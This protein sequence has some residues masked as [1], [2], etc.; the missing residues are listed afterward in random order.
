MRSI[1]LC[2]FLCLIISVNVKANSVI[3]GETKTIQGVSLEAIDPAC[4]TQPLDKELFY[5]LASSNI[6]INLNNRS[7]IKKLMRKQLNRKSDGYSKIQISLNNIDCTLDGEYRLT[8]DLTDHFSGALSSG[9]FIVSSQAGKNFHSIKVKL[10]NGSIDNIEKFKLLVPASRSGEA[11]VIVTHLFSTIGFLAPRTA[12]VN[13]LHDGVRRRLLFQEDIEKG[14]FEHNNVHENFL[15][16]GDEQYG[17]G[18]AFSMPVIVNDRLLTS[19]TKLDLA[20]Y[21]YHDLSMVYL[22]SGLLDPRINN[23]LDRNS[24]F[25]DSIPTPDFFP[26][27]SRDEITLFSMLS[28]ATN[29]YEGLS[30]D[31][32]RFIYDH[33]SRRFRP[34]YYDGHAAIYQPMHR[35][36]TPFSFDKRHREELIKKF[37]N[38]NRQDF[39][40]NL[41]RLGVEAPESKIENFLDSVLLNIEK[42]TAAKPQ[43]INFEDEINNIMSYWKNLEDY[44]GTKVL[45]DI[46]FVIKDDL[47]AFKTCNQNSSFFECNKIEFEIEKL[48]LNKSLLTQDLTSIQK[49]LTETV[50]LGNISSDKYFDR[51][52]LQSAIFNEI[53]ETTFLYSKGI[54]VSL[55]AE[56]KIIVIENTPLANKDQQVSISGGILKGWKIQTAEGTRLGY[57]FNENDRLSNTHLTGCITLSDIELIETT[58]SIGPSNCE[59]ALHFVRALGRNIKV[60]IQEARSDALDADFSNILFTS[61]DIF[62]AGNDCIDMS[63][64]TYLI[65]KAVLKQCGDKGI[66]GGEKS[67]IKITNVSIDGSLLGIVSK[68]SSI[69]DVKK[70]SISNT[71]VCLAAYRK[72]KE[73]LGGTINFDQHKCVIKNLEIN[74]YQQPGSYI[75]KL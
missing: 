73:F 42:L 70:F 24:Y 6:T 17:L 7:F 60:L 56:E 4:F 61:L 12:M 5:D 16:E 63:S 66:S 74:S 34:I 20:S 75:T 51:P 46:S 39:I 62:R 44:K 53:P 35:S 26:L 15:F 11:E 47:N 54:S 21:I 23:E 33:I 58:I 14:L 67:K 10:S 36:I 31:D 72:K 13:I 38:I 64:G 59:D 43:T 25:V 49:N 55:N 48:E 18:L 71:P 57:P 68:D 28:Y 40:N 8:G 2:F 41:R 19:L 37:K 27:T 1:L 22:K 69:I 45:N 9:D 52:R 29:T 3:I 30:K 50:Y 32:S 65:Q